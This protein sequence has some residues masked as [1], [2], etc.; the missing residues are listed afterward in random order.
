VLYF[1]EEKETDLPTLVELAN[2]ATLLDLQDA[3]R[4][5]RDAIETAR[6]I[7]KRDSFLVTF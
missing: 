3:V 4:Q 2:L 7:L 6:A 5:C 1:P